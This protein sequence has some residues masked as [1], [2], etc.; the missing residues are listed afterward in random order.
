M[1]CELE[2]ICRLTHAPG[3]APGRKEQHMETVTII[4]RNIPEDTR[5]ELKSRAAL[6]GISMQDLILRLIQE[7]LAR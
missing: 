6:E 1:S 4:L 3:P 5:R 2:R 7:Y